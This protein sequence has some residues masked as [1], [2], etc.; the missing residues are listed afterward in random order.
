LAQPGVNLIIQVHCQQKMT[1]RCKVT[2]VAKLRIHFLL[3]KLSGD[4]LFL[5]TF[6]KITV[7]YVG[8]QFDNL[9]KW[10]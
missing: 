2:A 9:K 5:G 6:R 10:F 7:V 1:G 4:I 3:I 8:K